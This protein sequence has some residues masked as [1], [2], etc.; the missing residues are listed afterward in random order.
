MKMNAATSAAFTFFSAQKRDY[1]LLALVR[2]WVSRSF[3]SFLNF[4]NITVS[5]SVSVD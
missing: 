4:S 3:A 5:Y 2:S 1:V